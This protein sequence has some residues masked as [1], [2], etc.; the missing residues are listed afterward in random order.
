M[1][2]DILYFYI[3]GS[4]EKSVGGRRLGEIAKCML[5]PFICA[6]CHRASLVSQKRAE[7]SK[8]F[9]QQCFVVVFLQFTK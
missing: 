4:S 9:T 3:F 6:W 2:I 8:L 7:Q 5:A 1:Q